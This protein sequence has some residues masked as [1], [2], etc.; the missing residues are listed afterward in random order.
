MI[1]IWWFNRAHHSEIQCRSIGCEKSACEELLVGL[2]QL[3]SR[4][5][6]RMDRMDRMIDSGYARKVNLVCSSSSGS[7]K[8]FKL[9]YLSYLYNYIYIHTQYLYLRHIEKS[10]IFFALCSGA[11]LTACSSQ[12]LG[13]ESSLRL[14]DQRNLDQQKGKAGA[15][16]ADGPDGQMGIFWCR[17]CDMA[18]S[19]G[20]DS[21]MAISKVIGTIMTQLRIGIRVGPKGFRNVPSGCDRGVWSSFIWWL[22]VRNLTELWHFDE[23]RVPVD[24]IWKQF[25]HG[26]EERLLYPYSSCRSRNLFGAWKIHIFIIFINDLQFPSTEVFHWNLAR[27]QCGTRQLWHQ[28]CRFGSACRLPEDLLSEALLQ[29]RPFNNFRGADGESFSVLGRC[30]T[31]MGWL[32]LKRFDMTDMTDMFL[33]LVCR[34]FCFLKPRTWEF[35]SPFFTRS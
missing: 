35:L 6:D 24:L 13:G 8:S 33:C 32:K 16:A 21:V 28:M 7:L 30:E 11:P 19:D 27:F 31:N 23:G 22:D 14:T 29:L 1:S 15:S 18:V 25:C 20:A 4:S 3:L 34:V 26:F 9:T 5:D 12:Q 10:I 2:H 17:R